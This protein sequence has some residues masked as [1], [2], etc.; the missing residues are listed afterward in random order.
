[1]NTPPVQYGTV[2]NYG[3]QPYNAPGGFAPA[4]GGYAANPLVRDPN[5][6]AVVEIV[7][8]LFGL[9]G[10]GHLAAGR[11][12]SGVAL[13]VASLAF[14]ALGWIVLLP[15]IFLTC[16]LGI[17]LLPLL[18][19]LPIA[20]GLWLRSDLIKQQPGAYRP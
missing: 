19:I 12:T 1:M 4:V 2:G 8:G 13:L 16:G 10:I 15:F 9:L 5:I 18:W 14:L 6:A 17:C 20:S 3:P 11:I 7:P